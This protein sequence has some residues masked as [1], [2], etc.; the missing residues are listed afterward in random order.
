MI[1]P[2]RGGLKRLRA[3]SATCDP[4]AMPQRSKPVPWL[5]KTQATLWTGLGEP[6]TAWKRGPGR[7]KV[8]VLGPRIPVRTWQQAA[9]FSGNRLPVFVGGPRISA[10]ESWRAEVGQRCVDRC[11]LTISQFRVRDSLEPTAT[12]RTVWLGIGSV[13]MLVTG[14]LKR[15]QPQMEGKDRW[16]EPVSADA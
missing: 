7:N 6:A 9:G 10:C 5:S 15:G 2:R 8:S 3:E 1:P 11:W 14:G 4:T 13:W 12:V 16:L